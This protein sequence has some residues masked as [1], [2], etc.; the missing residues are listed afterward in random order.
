MAVNGPPSVRFFGNPGDGEGNQ[1]H[2]Q[3]LLGL[4][5]NEFEKLS[6]KLEFVRLKTHHV[7]HEPRETLKSAY[8]C[9][10]GLISILSVFPNGKSV[11]VG[12]V[13][14]EGFIGVPLVAGFRTAATRAVTQIDATSFRVDSESLT[15]L[16][17]ECLHLE[18]AL[19]QS[20]QIL[21]MQVTQI[22]ACNRLHGVD[23]RLARWLLMSAERVGSNSLPLTQELLA[24]MLGARR[25]SVTVSAGTLQ[26][27]GLI[28]YNHGKLEIVDRQKLEAATCECYRI[29][30]RQVEDW[31]S[32]SE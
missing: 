8:F 16:L 26:K 15:K 5:R 29:M 20:S 11:E 3:I 31:Q 14:K 2:S 19:Q 10:S 25:A 12:L 13:G 27:K 24:Q 32:H 1:I 7:L 4:P 23:Q 22:A 28:S 17:Q 9:N 6:P 30:R 18:R 21:M